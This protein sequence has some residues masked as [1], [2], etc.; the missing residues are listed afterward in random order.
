MPQL[1]LILPAT[2][3]TLALRLQ[4]LEE[5]KFGLL[6]LFKSGIATLRLHLLLFGLLDLF[7][8]ASELLHIL[9]QVLKPRFFLKL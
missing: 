8:I 2:T 5:L 1:R 3:K 6:R 7:E 4:H 9:M